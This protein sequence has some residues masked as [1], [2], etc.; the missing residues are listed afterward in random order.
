LPSFDAQNGFNS[1]QKLRHR[2]LTGGVGVM[3]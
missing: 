1:I 2:C 3:I